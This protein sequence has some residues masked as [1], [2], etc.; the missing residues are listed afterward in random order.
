MKYTMH[1]PAPRE[2]RGIIML[3]QYEGWSAT[4]FDFAT[5]EQHPAKIEM[6]VTEGDR[7]GDSFLSGHRPDRVNGVK[8]SF[9]DHKG[10]RISLYGTPVAGERA[11]S[12]VYSN[13]DAVQT[14]RL[15]T[16]DEL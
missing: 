14:I 8:V 15:L 13:A 6:D 10:E 3:P 5:S 1:D 16:Q 9:M 2:H 11:L 4:W 7:W 12:V